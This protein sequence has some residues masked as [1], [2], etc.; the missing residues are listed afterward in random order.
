M[1]WVFGQVQCAWLGPLLCY[2]AQAPQHPIG[3]Y[4]DTYQNL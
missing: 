2:R 3:P 1:G 4:T